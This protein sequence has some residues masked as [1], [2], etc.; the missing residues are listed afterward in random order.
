M[1]TTF[2]SL[3]FLVAVGFYVH[4]SAYHP[5]LL[6][7]SKDPQMQ[8]QQQCDNMKSEKKEKNMRN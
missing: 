4:K 5:F 2:Y 8:Q 3:S 6:L 7:L 1:K